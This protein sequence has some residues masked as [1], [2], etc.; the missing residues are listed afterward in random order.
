M[1]S[2]YGIVP[3]SYNEKLWNLLEKESYT[4]KEIIEKAWAEGKTEDEILDIMTDRYVNDE[5]LADQT[6]SAYEINMRCTIR[7]Y[8]P[9]SMD[10]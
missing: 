10:S 2:H 9:K 5:R 6:F 3:E 8:K 7:L 4:E 1:V